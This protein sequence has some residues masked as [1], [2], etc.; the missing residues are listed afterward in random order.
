MRRFLPASAVIVL[1]LSLLAQNS[2]PSPDKP[3]Q[4]TVTPAVVS[5]R[6]V[7]AAEGNPLKSA[8]VALTPEHS[9]SHHQ[10]IYA[11]TTDADGHFLLKDVMPGRYYFFADRAGFVEQRYNAKN[12]HEGSILSLKEGEKVSDILFRLTAAAVITG[13]V[14]NEEG[15]GMMRVHVVAL[16]QPNEE[17]L[18]DE[19]PFRSRKRDLESVASAH[20]DDRGQYR[21]FGL[22]PG[23]YYIK[24]T[25]S[26]EPDH[27]MPVDESFWIQ[28]SMGSEYASAYYPGVAQAHQAQLVAVK[29]GDEAQADIMI[30]RV[31]TVE[32]AG[33]VIGPN[34]P[35]ADAMVHLRSPDL[36]GNSVDRNDT[37]DE[38]GAFRL[39]NVPE[40]TYSVVV[41]KQANDHVYQPAARQKIEV[42]GENIDSLIISLAGGIAIPGRVSLTGSGSV[43]FDRVSVNLISVEEDEQFG[44]HALAK[45]DGS[46]E[47]TSVRD[48]N[49]A[50]YVWGIGDGK[51]IKSIR[52]GQDD[53]LEKGLQIE[54]GTRTGRLDVMVSSDSAQLEG[55]VSDD[56]GPVIGAR[57]RIAPDPETHY[58]RFRS[59]RVTTDQLGHFSLTGVAPGKYQV[60][61]KSQAGSEA[62]T[63]K[64]KPE[65]VTLSESDHKLIQLKLEKPEE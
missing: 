18:E 13:R 55:S 53:V 17:E 40:G 33:H 8:H 12:G 14:V 21:I 11:T 19:G 59:Q 50:V 62:S 47:L 60:I 41:L 43:A 34:G 30:R 1:T 56:D 22:K 27:D 15:E 57:V 42:G 24:A 16:R 5:G 10:Q 58:N 36:D 6:V 65:T 61:A 35:A 46:F 2:T 31:K 49:Y 48:G 45:K 39:K 29:P 7:T 23:E 37:T 20:T 51:Y 4:H 52:W 26:Y 28:Q 3:S 54:G 44:G 25:D 32:V 38:K 64:S 9:S 63:L